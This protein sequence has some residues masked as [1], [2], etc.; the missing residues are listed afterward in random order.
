MDQKRFLTADEVFQ[1]FGIDSQALDALVE[2]GAVKALTDMGSFKY[3]SEDFAKLV[4]EGKLTP[5]TSGELFHAD[6][7]GDVPFLKIKDDE[8]GIKFD[9][10]VSFIELDEDALNAQAQHGEQV[11]RTPVVPDKWFDDSDESVESIPATDV[12]ASKKP[13]DA[14]DVE[15]T[16]G[17]SDKAS[18]SDVQVFDDNDTI[19]YDEPDVAAS[20]SDSD[21]RLEGPVTSLGGSSI[22]VKKSD[23]DSDVRLANTAGSKPKS[24]SDVTIAPTKKSG[25]STIAQQGA[26]KP[27]SDSDV[28]LASAGKPD[29]DSDVRLSGSAKPGS[30]V[31]FGAPDSGISLDPAAKSD[32][33]GIS[34]EPADSD[35]GI[36]LEPVAADSGISLEPVPD[37]GITLQMSKTDSDIKLEPDSGITLDSGDSGITLQSSMEGDSG[38]SLMDADSNIRLQSAPDSGIMLV[39]ESGISFADDPAMQSSETDSSQTQSLNTPSSTFDV[40][41]HEDERTMEMPVGGSS[42]EFSLL[43]E[44]D[45]VAAKPKSSP[46]PAPKAAPISDAIDL[47]DS[48]EVED[49]DISED[50]DSVSTGEFSGEFAEAEPEEVLEASD[51]DFSAHDGELEEVEDASDEDDYKPAAKVRSGPREP[52]WGMGAVIPIACSALLMAVCVTVLWGGISTMWTGAE[53]GGPAGILMSSLA[54]L[55]F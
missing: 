46:K 36:T 3:R 47:D 29:S 1:L 6:D 55:P 32:D 34:L 11:S 10:D 30:D 50:L 35:S 52:A 44:E 53:P 42:T 33:S 22:T 25:D 39:S 7:K 45:E 41:V 24:D 31:Q 23:G 54:G 37:S 43:P 2:S 13:S 9:Q 12:P 51:D 21:V 26:L 4:Q 19:D 20:A 27:D 38:I 17:H 5:R 8:R 16:S 40:S 14:T 49:L 28:Q 15:V 18:D 48:L